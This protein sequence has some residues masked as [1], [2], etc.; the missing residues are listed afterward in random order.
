MGLTNNFVYIMLTYYTVFC[1]ILYIYKITQFIILRYYI[2]VKKIL[3]G[4]AAY[5]IKQHG[6]PWVASVDIGGKIM[7]LK[8]EDGKEYAGY[9]S[10]GFNTGKSG[11][12]IVVNPQHNQVYAYGRKNYMRI[13]SPNAKSKDVFYVIY[14]NGVFKPCDKMGLL[15]DVWSMDKRKRK[16]Y[17]RLMG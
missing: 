14:L 8:K 11:N 12:L 15:L 10:G 4:Y 17:N 7:F 3:R 1:V 5:S 13:K 6:T 16:E 2:M 9:Y